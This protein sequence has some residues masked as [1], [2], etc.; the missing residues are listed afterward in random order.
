MP[1]MTVTEGI[2]TSDPKR[3]KTISPLHFQ[4]Y[5]MDNH[6]FV[7]NVVAAIYEKYDMQKVER[8]Y[9]HADGGNWIRALGALMPKAVFVMDGFHL[10][11]YL[12]K[13][14]RL[15]GA[16][17]YSG[18]VRKAIRE[19]NFD[20]FAGYISSISEK[21]DEKGRK[22]LFELVTYFQNN[23]DS[24]VERMNSTHCGSCTEPLIS[25]TLSERLSR[26]PLAWSKE[27]LGKMTMLR[28]FEENGGIVTAEHIRISRD[29]SARKRDFNALKNGLEIYNKYAEEQVR[30]IFSGKHDWIIFEKNTTPAAFTYGKLTGTSVLLKAFARLKAV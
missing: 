21:Q 1:L 13:L 18:V 27:G 20:A 29:K 30:S 8:V 25:H 4:G 22:T 16:V 14:F 12:K 23:W 24:I 6:A 7:D 19:N 26:N 10:E 28:V 11:K 3:H 5:G 2:D 17:P 9:I 15:N